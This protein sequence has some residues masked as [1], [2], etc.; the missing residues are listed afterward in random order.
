MCDTL[1]RGNE[2]KGGGLVG[3][4]FRP[5]DEQ[6]YYYLCGGREAGLSTCSPAY[7]PSKQKE[8]RENIFFSLG[9]KKNILFWVLPLQATAR[10][11]VE[12][13]FKVW[14]IQ[15]GGGLPHGTGAVH[16]QRRSVL[17]FKGMRS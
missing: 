12:K 2:G 4:G 6:Y 11:K 13:N 1:K 15:A 14:R 8:E 7:A 9:K 5:S 10:F 3:A 17:K 16:L